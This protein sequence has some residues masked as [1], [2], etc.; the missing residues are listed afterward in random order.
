MSVQLHCG[1]CVA[2]MGGIPDSSVDLVATDPPYG[3]GYHQ[4]NQSAYG[5]SVKQVQWGSI[6]GDTAPTG[7]WLVEAY[8][9]LKP[10]SALYLITRWDVEP[11]WR[12]H[13]LAAGFT[14]KQRL[15]WHKRVTGKGDLQGT[16]SPSCE[17]ILFASKSRH[18]LNRRLSM[19]LD[20]GCVPTW[21]HRFHPHQK[22]VGLMTTLIETSTR[23]GE[24]VFDPFMGSGT[25]GV[26]CVRTGRN[27]IG[28]EI[29]PGYCAIAEKRIAAE[30]AKTPLLTG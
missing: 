11:E 13:L 9:V 25:T 28:S 14:L 6:A 20:A 16:Y 10:G 18:I 8:R 15:T 19:L 30:L 17:D 24:T 1:D 12:Q 2:V 23:E 22:P 5:R 21:E 3:V 4:G 27:F 26:A 7:Q 29:D